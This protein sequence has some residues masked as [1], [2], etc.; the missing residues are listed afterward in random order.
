[1][2]SPRL[3]FCFPLSH[4]QVGEQKGG[5]RYRSLGCHF[6][7]RLFC[8]VLSCLVLFCPVLSC[9]QPIHLAITRSHVIVANNE[10]VYVWQ[11]RLPP[12]ALTS[13]SSSSSSTSA[14][15]SSSASSYSSTRNGLKSQSCVYTVC[16]C[17]GFVKRACTLFR[18]G[19]M[20]SIDEW[21]SCVC[22]CVRCT[23][24]CSFYSV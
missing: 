20:R 12:A 19:L 17:I 18:I 15:S 6:V 23:W 11:Y 14:S 16:V 9:S 8:L 24:G 7:F 22:I 21:K 4:G 1:M 5:Y 3:S 13:S 2:F 10:V